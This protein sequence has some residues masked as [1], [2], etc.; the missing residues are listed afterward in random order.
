M[1]FKQALNNVIYFYIRFVF[2]HIVFLSSILLNA[3]NFK[4]KLYSENEFIIEIKDWQKLSNDKKI[5][6]FN[7]LEN[8][9][10][11]IN[12]SLEVI[13]LK[14]Y[15][16]VFKYHYKNGVINGSVCKW[17]VDQ[18]FGA[19]PI[20]TFYYKNGARVFPN[21]KPVRIVD[22]KLLSAIE[23][24]NLDFSHPFNI[25]SYKKIK[26]TTRV[27]FSLITEPFI[28][29]L[30]PYLTEDS[31]ELAICLDINRGKCLSYFRYTFSYYIVGIGEA[32][33]IFFKVNQ[34]M[35][36][37]KLIQVNQEKLFPLE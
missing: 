2:I 24:D 29:D 5:N 26:D 9:G 21:E 19:K 20:E 18:L 35:K 3:Q 36:N 10:D 28:F 17:S 30:L 11:S 22:F 34:Y 14:T 6:L 1:K 32:I 12:G 15:K 13:D 37:G 23:V 7:I 8:P 4:I 33:P 16:P 25:N 31:N 27:C